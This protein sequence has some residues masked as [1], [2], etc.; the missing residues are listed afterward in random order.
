[1]TIIS[2]IARRIASTDA[3]AKAS[4]IIDRTVAN[5]K[6]YFE[7]TMVQ[8][9][10]ATNA[11]S[12]FMTT[13]SAEFLKSANWEFCSHPNVNSPAKCLVAPIKGFLAAV[14]INTLNDQTPVLFQPAHGGGIKMP[15]SDGLA[16]ECVSSDIKP[17]PVS[18]TYLIYGGPEGQEVMW[19]VFPGEPTA[20]TTPISMSSIEDLFP[21]RKATVKEAKELG[22]TTIKYVKSL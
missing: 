2:K 20:K 13:P 6:E 4:E 15:G 14:D 17:T 21:D 12:Y 22:F 8:R 16:A 10:K 9:T 7:K 19:T 18:E 11:G 1:M 5:N 3:T